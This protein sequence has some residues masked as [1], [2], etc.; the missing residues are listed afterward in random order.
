MGFSSHYEDRL[1]DV[2]TLTSVISRKWRLEII[3][4]L[5]SRDEARFTDIKS[6]IDGISKKM[7]SNSLRNLR[8]LN[9]IEKDEEKRVYSV[10]KK[11]KELLKQLDELGNLQRRFDN[12]RTTVLI[13]EDDENQSRMYGRWMEKFAEV[14]EAKNIEKAESQLDGVD[15]VFVDRILEGSDRGEELLEKLDSNADQVYKVVL[16]VLTA[17]FNI[18][19]MDIDDYLVKPVS[20]KDMIAA[21][22][23]SVENR[24][25]TNAERNL[26]ALLLKKDLLM[27]EYTIKELEENEEFNQLTQQI[28]ELSGKI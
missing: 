18:I 7:L 14:R 13:V 6:E 26:Q 23:R 24:M 3:Y 5:S 16:T 21:I 10:S 28:D 11:G 27:Q 2:E 17:D 25:K 1:D 12:K 19:R 8:K 20:R 4:V 9:I 22:D 15:I